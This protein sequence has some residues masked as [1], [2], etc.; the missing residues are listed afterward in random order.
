MAVSSKLASMMLKGYWLNKQT[1]YI[2]L[3]HNKFLIVLVRG[4]RKCT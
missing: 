1:I 2:E 3:F 4:E